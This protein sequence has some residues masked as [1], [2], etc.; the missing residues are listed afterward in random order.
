MPKLFPILQEV[1]TF[2]KDWLRSRDRESMM[3]GL[4]AALSVGVL[5]TVLALTFTRSSSALAEKY[6]RAGQQAWAA[7]Q[8]DAA[9]L[10]YR[11]SLS[12]QPDAKATLIEA[13]RLANERGNTKQRDAFLGRLKREYAYPEAFLMSAVF[14]LQSKMPLEASKM[15]EAEAMLEQALALD[16][17]LKAQPSVS[18]VR[19]QLSAAS[20][21]VGNLAKARVHL[22]NLMA[23]SS[24]DRLEMAS[25]AKQAEDKGQAA[26]LANEVLAELETS[27]SHTFRSLIDRAQAHAI[28]DRASAASPFLNRAR[29]VA[30]TAEEVNAW[31]TA[32]LWCFEE[33]WRGD[34]AHPPFILLEQVLAEAP[35]HG[36]LAALL[37]RLSG[38]G[39]EEVRLPLTTLENAFATGEALVTAHL[40][41]G[42]HALR[43]EDEPSASG[44]SALHFGIAGTLSAPSSLALSRCSLVVAQQDPAFMPKALSL[45]QVALDLAKQHPY[46]LEI[47]SHLLGA[48]GL[49]QDVVDLLTPVAK[50]EQPALLNLLATAHEKLGDKKLEESYRP[51]IKKSS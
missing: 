25:I 32:T 22:E 48:N 15:D 9:D 16:E 50:S 19:R 47:R 31:A 5:V 39:A 11:K 30:T 6:L 14:L 2:V 4:P 42:L 38:W 1:I 8:L 21:S 26:K 13:V 46:A 33:L 41:L 29:Q 34:L 35:L 49:W 17:A 24:I 43:T 18:Q 3:Q 40:L 51:H 28:L 36:S 27:S 20:R 10:Y 7:G 37:V 45:S 12:A 23:P 44:K